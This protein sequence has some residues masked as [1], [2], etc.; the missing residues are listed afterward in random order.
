VYCAVGLAAA[1]LEKSLD[2]KSFLVSHLVPE[3]QIPDL[4][5]KILRRR[6]SI[7]VGQWCTI[8]TSPESRPLYFQLF[9]FLLNKDDPIN[10]QVVR[11]SAGRQLSR[12][13]DAYECTAQDILPYADSVLTEVMAL[14]EEVEHPE[15]KM[16]LLN[17]ISNIVFRLEHH[18]SAHGVFRALLIWSR[19]RLMLIV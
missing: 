2:F 11:V 12:A 18:V 14:V 17:T 8:E 6:I 15:T 9:Q 10:D 19:L 7:L 5:Y 3:V 16:A 4:Q 1:N 13:V